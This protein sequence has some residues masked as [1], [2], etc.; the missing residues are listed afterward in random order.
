MPPYRARQARPGSEETFAGPRRVAARQGRQQAMRRV[1]RSPVTPEG[2]AAYAVGRGQQA[3]RSAGRAR[4]P[5][6]DRQY[7]GV[8]LAEFVVAVLIVA[9][10]PIARGK[11]AQDSTPGPSPYGPDDVKQLAG[12]GAV[13]LVLA[14]LSSGRHGRLAAWFGGLVLI[15]IGLSE[16][17]SGGLAGL[18][19]IFQ[20]ASK[21]SGAA[22]GN[23]AS[24]I[25]ALG[26]GTPSGGT[27]GEGDGTPANQVI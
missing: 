18:F 2:A 6:G 13:Y 15:A 19:G 11:A 14:L 1:A 22:D 3:A 8:I 25:G 24:G 4:I 17:T 7:Q 26:E 27:A 23:P 12:I 5:T 10:A 20:P 21:S 16:T 9:L